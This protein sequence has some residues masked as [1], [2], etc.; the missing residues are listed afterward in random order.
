MLNLGVFMDC[1]YN[2]RIKGMS[3]SWYSHPNV[4]PLDK[5]PDATKNHF[6]VKSRQSLKVWSENGWTTKESPLGWWQWYANYHQGRR[7]VKEDDWQI[8]RWRS[9][10]AR[11]MGQ[12]KANCSLK[13]DKCRPVQRQALLQWAWDSSTLFSEE[14]KI[15]N[16][17]RLGVP[18]S[19]ISTESMPSFLKW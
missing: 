6:G 18:T 8:G 10:V 17:K 15:N 12:I 14:Q 5:E 9:F 16:L 4:Y 3:A 11:H 7:L 2:V 19:K 1:H 13:D